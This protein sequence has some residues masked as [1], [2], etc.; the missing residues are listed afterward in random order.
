[1]SKA[2]IITIAYWFNDVLHSMG[3]VAD[4]DYSNTAQDFMDYWRDR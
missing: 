2:K 1:M 4:E 3:L